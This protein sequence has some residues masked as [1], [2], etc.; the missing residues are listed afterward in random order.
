MNSSVK[1][2]EERTEKNLLHFASA[3]CIIGKALNDRNSTDVH[4]I[5][6]KLKQA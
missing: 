4:R 6:N 5:N 3:I 1:D 2:E